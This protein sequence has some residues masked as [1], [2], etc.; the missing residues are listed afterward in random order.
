MN[1]KKLLLLSIFIPVLGIAQDINDPFKDL[2]KVEKIAYA[3]G[4]KDAVA[5]FRFQANAEIPQP[6]YWVLKDV[7]GKP[8]EEIVVFYLYAKQKGY[9]PVVAYNKANGRLYLVL[10]SEKTKV[11][12]Q[13]DIENLKPLKTFILPVKS[14]AGFVKATTYG[15]CR[16][17]SVEPTIEGAIELV[18]GA[19]A[20]LLKN[21]SEVLDEDKVKKDFSKV[22]S[23]LKELK[24]KLINTKEA[25]DNLGD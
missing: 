12:A 9:S 2:T 21:Y 8:L 15:I 5:F 22:I 4:V 16:P 23:E 13:K 10:S 17:K 18:E 24:R 14:I 1:L 20:I 25:M 11:E 19:E 7:S 3:K 6:G